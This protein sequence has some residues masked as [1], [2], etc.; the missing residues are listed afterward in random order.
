MKLKWTYRT[1]LTVWFAALFL[2]FAAVLVV[3]QIRQDMNTKKHSL[4]ERLEAYADAIS[5]T[6]DY[7]G[8]VALFPKEMRTTVI[9]CYGDV[10]YDSADSTVFEVNHLDRPEVVSALEHGR[11]DKVRTSETTGIPYFYF[12]KS[13]DG[14]VVRVALPYDV[15]VRRFFRPDNLFLLIVALLFGIAVLMIAFLSD[16]FGTGVADTIERQNR[17]L[18]QQMTSNVSHELRTPVTSI[19]GYLETL[20]SCPDMDPQKRDVFIQRAYSQTVRLSDLIRDMALISKIEESPEKLPV[21]LV[22]FADVAAEVF[23][24]FADR[25]ARQGVNVE[26]MLRTGVFIHANRTLVYAVLRNLVENSLKYAG[27]GVTLHIEC[28]GSAEG[29]L[30]FVYY[31]TGAGVPAEHLSHLFERF[32]RVSEGRSRDDGGSGLGLSIVRNAVVF[33]GGDITASLREPSGL[34]FSFS[35]R[36]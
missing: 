35:L 13:Y 29:L 2:A 30:H 4:Q 14:M 25:I 5:H 11:G 33:H 9:D 27:E 16:R 26:N 10:I 8:L 15:Q 1:Q 21:E 19:R 23:E 6:S 24:E 3:F 7:E 34:M 12:A 20:V 36:R 17:K 32:Y 28:L 22:D 31:D 18:K